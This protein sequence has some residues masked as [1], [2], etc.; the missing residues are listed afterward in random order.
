MGYYLFSALV[1]LAVIG[2]IIALVV[3]LVKRKKNPNQP[4]FDWRRFGVGVAMSIMLPF[5]ISFSTSAV[6]NELAITISFISMIIMA[7]VFLI[8][9]LIVS[10]HTVISTS[11]IIGAVIEIIV[12]FA[13]NMNSVPP[14]VMAILA[15]LGLAVL[16]FFA[17]KK[18]Q[19][20]EVK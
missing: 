19:E 12:A 15:G 20:Q 10:H 17:Y 16:I 4:V 1:P 7:V 8:I 9:G 14:S 13:Y 3:W 18:M 2:G 11:L 6:F 5:F